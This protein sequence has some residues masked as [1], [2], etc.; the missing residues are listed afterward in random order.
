MDV[1]KA[2]G[3]DMGTA[4]Y[5]TFV[6]ALYKLGF[7]FRASRKKGILQE[8]DLRDRLKF[9]KSMV[10]TSVDYWTEKVAF[11]L[12]GV[13]FVYKTNPASDALKPRSKV[14]RKRSEGLVVT[15]K[16]SKDLAGG[17]RLHLLV[18]ISYG[19]GVIMAEPYE[20][21]NSEFCFRLCE[22]NVFPLFLKSRVTRE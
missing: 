22:D 11:Y 5:Q 4:H 16:G 6:R 7:S 21:M 18:A 19:Q 1:V 13:S 20:K 14:W 12:D 8:K 2:S 10:S 3:L 15:T 9:A 17:K